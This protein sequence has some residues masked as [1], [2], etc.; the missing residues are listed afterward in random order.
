MRAIEIAERILVGRE[1]RGD[2]VD[3]HADAGLMQPIDHRHEVLGRAEPAGRGEVAGDLI[4]PASIERMLGDRH[5]LDM[6]VS[7]F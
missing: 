5:Q 4:A 1:V 7:E 6:G 2:P 3:D